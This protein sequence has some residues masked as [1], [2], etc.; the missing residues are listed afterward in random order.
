MSITE[1]REEEK[2]GRV[3]AILDAALAMFAER[4]YTDTN[5]E[6]ISRAA[7]LGKATLYYYF[8]TKEEIFRTLVELKSREYYA[9]AYEVIKS[10]TRPPRIVRLLVTFFFDYFRRRPQLLSLFFP[11]GRSSP[12]FLKREQ[13]LVHLLNDLRRPIDEHLR[14][15]FDNA[16]IAIDSE[17]MIRIIWTFIIGISV[18]LVQ[19]YN[20]KQVQKEADIFLDMIS[21]SLKTRKRKQ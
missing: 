2:Q 10:E 5:M 7:R 8:K 4:G 9:A 19:G 20:F 18:K 21:N 3:N 1:R 16:R 17:D 11:F 14:T 15:S 13:R 6:M 12:L